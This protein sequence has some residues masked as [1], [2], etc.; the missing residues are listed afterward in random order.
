MM[1]RAWQSYG[2]T[3]TKY[4]SVRPCREVGHDYIDRQHGKIYRGSDILVSR[5]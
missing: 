2:Y 3:D 1:S 4:L 5:K